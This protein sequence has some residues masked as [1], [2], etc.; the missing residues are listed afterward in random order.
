MYLSSPD[1]FRNVKNRAYSL[2]TPMNFY[3]FR[4]FI[5]KMGRK[6]EL[7]LCVQCVH[8]KVST[9]NEFYSMLLIIFAYI[10]ILFQ[11][12]RTT[13]TTVC[14]CVC[15]SFVHLF[16]ALCIIYLIRLICATFF[17]R[18]ATYSY[19]SISP[20]LLLVY[21]VRRNADHNVCINRLYAHKHLSTHLRLNASMDKCE[22]AILISD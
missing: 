22:S 19:Y 15:G 8:I 6:R 14:V 21:L 9:E 16:F 1:R 2:S 11:G 12:Y 17:S 10:I 7:L 20:L 3:R 13:A 18:L 4:H 5:Q